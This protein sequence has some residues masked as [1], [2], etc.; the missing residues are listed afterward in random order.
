MKKNITDNKL[1]HYDSFFWSPDYLEASSAWIEHIPFAFWIIEVLK[2]KTLVE[3]GVHSATSY[4]SFCQAVKRMNIDTICYGVD[5]WKGDEHAGFYSEEVFE[6]VTNYNTKEFSRFSTLIKSTFDEAKEYFIDGSIDLLHIDGLH[7]YEA[8]KHDFETWLPKLSDNSLVIFHDINVREKNFGVFKL[9][10]ELK[11][12]YQ[13][14]QFD[15][16]YGLGILAIDKIMQP[17]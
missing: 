12:K 11:Q 15:F 7:T 8:V 14:F 17:K 1:V 3:L 2:P 13:H 6:K 5:T 16:G 9:W 4:F 10:E